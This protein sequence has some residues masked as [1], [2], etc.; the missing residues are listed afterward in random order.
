VYSLL[1]P[2]LFRQDPEAIHHRVVSGLAFASQRFYLLAILTALCQL[3]DARLSTTAFGLDFPNAIGLAAGMDKNAL[4]VPAWQALGFGHVEIGSVT[5]YEQQGNP[6]PRLFRLP[7]DEALINRMGFNNDGAERIAQRLQRLRQRQPL[8]IPLGVNLGKSKR[9]PLD[10]APADYLASL[11]KLWHYADYFVINVSSPNTPQLRQLQDKERLE[12]LLQTISQFSSSQTT[13]RPILLKIAP[14]LSWQQ[15]DKIVALVYDYQLAGII[16][17]NTTLSRDGLTTPSQE[18][19]GL[20]GRPLRQRSYEV[21]EY[22][23][24]VSSGNMP[25]VSVGGISSIGDVQRRLDAGA[26]LVQL[27]TSLVYQGPFH[28]KQLKKGLLD[29]L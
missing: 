27:Y 22:L 24:K 10:Q 23:A 12:E 4:A 19:G 17:T 20:S 14:D 5:A 18:Q 2:L 29:I 28:I 26:V 6:R 16:A 8:S 7:E 25:L 9:T 13:A 1:K 15:I 3:R 11:E 21:L